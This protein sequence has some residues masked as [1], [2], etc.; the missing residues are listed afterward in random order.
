VN[1]QIAMTESGTA[2]QRDLAR[3]QIAAALG[4]GDEAV[5]LLRQ[6]PPLLWVTV[7]L[8]AAFD[9]IRSYPPFVALMTPR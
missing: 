1:D 5:R 8:D 6:V 4:D 3:A 2:V 7:H 9:E